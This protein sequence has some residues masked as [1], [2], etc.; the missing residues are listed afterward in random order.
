MEEKRQ[1]TTVEPK[2]PV[3]VA[4]PKKEAKVAIPNKR[5]LK[6]QREKDKQLVKGIFNFLEVPGGEMKF[7]YSK[8][9]GEQPKKYKLKDGEVYS[10]PLG[11]AKHLNKNCWY[12][13]H[14]HAVDAEGKP[15]YKVGERKRRCGFQSLEFLDPEDFAV[16]DPVIL[17]AQKV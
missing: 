14:S 13:V 15:I 7:V 8:Y 4:I 11:V 9:K 16:N 3:Q 2:R 1:N 12:P 17:T 6:F 5:N 10:L